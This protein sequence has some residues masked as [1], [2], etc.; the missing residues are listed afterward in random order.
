MAKSAKF[1]GYSTATS[2]FQN[3][4]NRML[5]TLAPNG[6]SVWDNTANN[7]RTSWD[8]NDLSRAKTVQVTSNSGYQTH[9]WAVERQVADRMEAMSFP[10]IRYA[11]VLLNFAEA[12][13]GAGHYDE[14][15]NAL[16]Q[17]RARVGYTA[18]N[19]Y[20]LPSGINGDRASLFAAIL[21]ERQVELAFEGDRYDVM[22][23]WM[24]FDGGAGQGAIKSSWAL[25]GFSGNTCNY[26]GVK[27][28]N[29]TKR[30]QIVLYCLD[31]GTTDPTEGNRPD[32]ITLDEDLT[33]TDGTFSD[34]KVRELAEFYDIFLG[35]KDVNLDGNDEALTIKYRPTYYFLGLRQNAMQTNPT[36]HQTVGWHDLGRNADGL[37]D[38]LSDTLPE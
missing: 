19:N 29:G 1:Q 21:Y 25:T 22:H 28:L 14:A 8:D 36:L 37:F 6:T 23:R 11:E 27:P 13:C 30:H 4:D 38:P 15:V 5:T 9:K 7:C 2:E 34:K 33:S 26:L 3:R 10:V 18:E 24:L 12:A 31:A 16:Q 20:G 35:R 17:I 32:A